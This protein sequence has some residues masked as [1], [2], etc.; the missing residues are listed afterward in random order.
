MLNNHDETLTTLARFLVDNAP[1]GA[2]RELARLKA[3]LV[4]GEIPDYF[5][6]EFR[7]TSDTGAQL[8]VRVEGPDGSYHSSRVMDAEGNRW[9]AYRVKCEI[10]WAS[11][12]SASTE[13]CQR[14]LAVMTEV[15]RFACEVERAF[16]DVFHRLD[17]TA[18]EIK[19]QAKAHAKA[20]AVEEIRRQVR[21][22]S[23]GMKVGNT[24]SFFV[25]PK[26]DLADV[27]EVQVERTEGGRTFKYNASVEHGRHV[28]EPGL[29][30]FMR[31]EA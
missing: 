9:Y 2:D 10:S 8:Y 26:F 16:P 19:E 3:D 15:T 7:P 24:K 27:G 1:P 21:A 20:C 5:S 4:A 28:G 30:Y 12:G 18:A 14:R 6:L 13:V 23:K 25:G 31:I 11:W 22:L 17:A 29:V